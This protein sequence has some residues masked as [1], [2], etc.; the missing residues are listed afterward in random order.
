MFYPLSVFI[1]MRYTRA[2]R[3]S[4][5]VSFISGISMLGLIVAVS[6]LIVVLSVMNGF[7]RE[8]R[9]RIL[10]LVPQITVQ[11]MSG[12]PVSK[13][14]EAVIAN[15]SAV[16]ASAPF[17]QLNGMLVRGQAVEAVVVYAV[18]PEREREVSIIDRY[19]AA[20]TL[21]TLAQQDGILIGQPLAEKL[22]LVKGDRLTLLVPQQSESGRLQPLFKSLSVLDIFNTGTEID[23]SIAITSLTTAKA[24]LVEQTLSTAL[25]VRVNDSFDA[26]RIAWELHQQLPF[27]YSV[28]NWTQRYGNLYSAIQLSRQL[29]VLMLL[30][31]IAVA[32]F[33]VVCA[34]VMI[35][36]EKRGDIAILRT[37]GVSRRGIVA[38]FIVQGTVI[39]VV[40]TLVGVLLGAGLALS[41]T[42]IVGWIE[43]VAGVHFL[44]SDVYPVNYLPSDLRLEDLLLVGGAS[45]LVSILATIYPAWRASRVMPAE[46]LRYE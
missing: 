35:V 41:V 16:V 22:G 37:Q 26:P 21:T 42:Q 29:V 27:S 19:L 38:I 12:L 45:L 25:R 10:G 30:G 44:N 17:A 43:R 46:A 32:A 24:M 33:N 31:I 5:M 34:L 39:G 7:D 13:T 23:Q 15:H 2:R 18:D 8:M 40:G 11:D 6:L 3:R 14:A 36:T 9:E 1:G 4:Q 20:D 28:G